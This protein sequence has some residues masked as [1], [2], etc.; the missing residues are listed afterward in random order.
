MAA[1]DV[2]RFQVQEL[3]LEWLMMSRSPMNECAEY[4]RAHIQQR[5]I[6]S[7]FFKPRKPKCRL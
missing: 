7:G 3:P 4:E 1:S 6:P 2:H 5:G